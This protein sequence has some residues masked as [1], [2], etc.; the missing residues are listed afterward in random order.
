MRGRPL[1]VRS[2]NPRTPSCFA[3][4][5][6]Q[7]NLPSASA[8]WPIT[9][10]PQWAQAGASAWMAHSNE[11]NQCDFSSDGDLHRLVVFISAGF[12][13]RHIEE[14]GCGSHAKPRR[15]RTYLRRFAA[16]A[17]SQGC[18]CTSYSFGAR[19][20]DAGHY[21]NGLFCHTL[22]QAETSSLFVD[23]FA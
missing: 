14:R 23:P 18:S 10:Q 19:R 7:K 13:L 11:S 21:P 16:N 4:C 22:A 8:P 5:A 20:A 12:A 9:L 3:Q 1:H 17:A 15:S 6:Q 2:S